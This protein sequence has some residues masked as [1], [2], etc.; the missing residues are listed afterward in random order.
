VTLHKVQFSSIFERQGSWPRPSFELLLNKKSF[1]NSS[2]YLKGEQAMLLP[3]VVQGNVVHGRHQ[4]WKREKEAF[5]GRVNDALLG[6]QKQSE[7]TQV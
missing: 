4:A 7:P 2:T 1:L 3:R 5:K 6:L